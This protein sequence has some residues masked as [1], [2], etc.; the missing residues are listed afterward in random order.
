MGSLLSAIWDATPNDIRAHTLGD[1]YLMRRIVN[2]HQ[3]H[4]DQ[5]KELLGEKWKDLNEDDIAKMVQRMKRDGF[6]SKYISPQ[7]TGPKTPEEYLEMI[8]DPKKY[9]Y[10]LKI[11]AFY[12]AL[13]VNDIDSLYLSWNVTPNDIRVQVLGDLTWMREIVIYGDQWQKDQFKEF[14]DQKWKE[15]NEEEIA[16]MVQWMKKHRMY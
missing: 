15:L 12:K 10:G 4:K 11:L 8:E 2:G 1:L 7:W 3:F 5:F 16:E 9:D 6:W 14:L 13:E